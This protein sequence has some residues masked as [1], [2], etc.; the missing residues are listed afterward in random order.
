MAERFER[1]FRALDRAGVRYLVV[2]GVA[3]V[4]HGYLRTTADLDLVIGLEPENVARAVG[5]LEQ[6]GFRPRAP[7]PLRSFADPVIRRSWIETKHLQVFSLW[8]EEL[9]GFEVD[10]F[11][12]EPFDFDVAWR[13]RVEVPLHDTTAAVVCLEDLL[14]LKR[15]AGRARDLEDVKALLSLQGDDS[16]G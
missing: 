3:V 2:G 4:L 13:R 11:V 10:L 9:P 15:S 1:V 14:S 12:E 7:V 8:H 5:A 6:A 16:D